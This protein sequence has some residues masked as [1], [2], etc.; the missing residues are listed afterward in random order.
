MKLFQQIKYWSLF[1]LVT[2][3]LNACDKNDDFEDDYGDGS[4]QASNIIIR[5]GYQYEYNS[6][7][8]ITVINRIQ[9]KTDEQ[10]N[11]SNELYTVARISY[12]QSNRAVM[13][14]T[15]FGN[16]TYV[17]AF[18]TN[19]FAHRIIQTDSDGESYLTEVSH[20]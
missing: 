3:S 10:G 19:N 1:V 11:T 13:E 12:P 15:E 6:N 16:T 20:P 18:G 5:K 9:T 17:F 2:L 4:P 7:G 8:L 14:T